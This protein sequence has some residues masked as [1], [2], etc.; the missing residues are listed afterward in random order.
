MIIV[1]GTLTVD[2]ADRSLYLELASAAT[3]QARLIPECLDFAQSADPLES[4]RINIFERWESD[5]G[6]EAFRSLPDDGVQTP[7]ILG[8]DVHR[9]RISSVE[10][11]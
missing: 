11:A 8:A 5:A 9:Y 6:L 2:P 4:D 7:P 10:P 1:A 3:A